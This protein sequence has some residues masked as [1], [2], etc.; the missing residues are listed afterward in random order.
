VKLGAIKE[1]L[2]VGEGDSNPL[3]SEGLKYALASQSLGGVLLTDPKLL[4]RTIKINLVALRALQAKVDVTVK[5]PDEKSTE[6][7]KNA[8]DEAVKKAEK[9]SRARTTALR[10]YI[11]GLALVAATSDPDLNLREGCNLRISG[12][13]DILIGRKPPCSPKHRARNSLH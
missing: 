1:E 11:L 6:D 12:E 8:Y 13:D 10:N 2:D 9:Q 4:V 5:K 3:S 7:E